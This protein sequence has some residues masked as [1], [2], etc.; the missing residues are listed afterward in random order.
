MMKNGAQRLFAVVA[1]STF[2]LSILD[3]RSMRVAAICEI[4]RCS[5]SSFSRSDSSMPCAD[6]S[7]ISHANQGQ[8]RQERP[9]NGPKPS[10]IHPKSMKN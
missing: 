5:A 9:R 3:S 7:F 1:I 10:K 4:S 8:N 6:T 2:S